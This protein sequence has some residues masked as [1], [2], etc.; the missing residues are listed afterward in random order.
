MTQQLTVPGESTRFA[1]FCVPRFEISSSGRTVSTGVVRD[2][3]QVTYNDS[4]TEIDSFDITV[5]NWDATARTFKYVCGE[6]SVLGDTPVQQLF[7]PGAGEF[8]LKLG[9]GSELVTM[10]RGTTTSL[11]PSFP[12]GGAPTLTVRALNALHQLRSRQH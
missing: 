3:L 2:V 5:N 12:A 7:N 10:M 4:T 8:E 6:E 9:Y 1:D 11:E